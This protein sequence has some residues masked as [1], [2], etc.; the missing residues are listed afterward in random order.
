MKRALIVMATLVSGCTTAGLVTPT[1]AS[2]AVDTT[3]PV[4]NLPTKAT[5]VSGTTIGETEFSTDN[6]PLATYGIVMQAKWTASD[7]SGICGSSWRK[8]YAGQEPGPWTAWTSAMQMKQSA[9]DYADQEGGGVFKVDGYDVRV[10]DCRNHITRKFVSFY[11]AVFQE[12]GSSYG[13]GGVTTSYTGTWRL[14]RCTCWSGHTT[15]KSFTKGATATFTFDQAGPVGLVME[16]APDRGRIRILVDG[17]LR[18]S[19]DTYSATRKHRSVVWIG[20]LRGSGS[21]TVTV[22]NLA[23]AGRPR[24]DVDAMLVSY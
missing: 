7:A 17:V 15:R 10:R 1:V 19:P 18:A 9:T 12:D 24:V 11:P 22:K 6:E 20:T 4:L 2:A 13:Y 5:F 21:H 8:V 16:K 14:S 23:T 3:P